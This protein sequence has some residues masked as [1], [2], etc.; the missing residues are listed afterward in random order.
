MPQTKPFNKKLPALTRSRVQGFTKKHLKP[1]PLLVVIIASTFTF[2]NNLFLFSVSGTYIEGI[3]TQDTIWTLTDS[4]FVVSKNITVYPNVTLTIEPSVEVKFGG[5]FSLIVNGKLIANGMQD[6]MITFTSNKD[7]PGAGDW[8]AIEFSGIQQSMLAFCSIKYA[9]NG[10][11]IKDGNV[12]IHNCEIGNNL[13]NGMAIEN[14]IVEAKNNEIAR[15]SENGIYITGYTQV[16]IQNNTIRSNANGILLT[17]NSTIG[18]NIEDNII[19]SNT[20]NG[21]Q[22]NAN[23][24]SNIS[25]LNNTISANNNGFYV[26]GQANTYITNNSIS[27]NTIG[28]FYEYGN[29]HVAYYNDVYGNDYGMDVSPN[30]TVNAEYNY[31]GHESGPYHVSLN[32][33]GKGNPV[34]G[35][36]VNLDFIFFLTAPI[37]YINERPKGH[38]LSYHLKRRQTG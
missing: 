29:D 34:C 30:A 26:S 22:L 3:I 38:V 27:Y 21:I 31:W 8:N 6:K 28:I 35:D 25:I 9:K 16:I 17:G 7:Q 18:V 36:G 10:T 11:T 37:G 13:E 2:A 20:Q 32:P 19:M 33:T 15:N 4:P 14:S 23:E 12:R 1:L 24:Y 5:E